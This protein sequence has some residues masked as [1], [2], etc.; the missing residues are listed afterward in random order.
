VGGIPHIQASETTAD[1]LVWVPVDKIAELTIYPSIND[2]ILDYVH[3]GKKGQYL[4]TLKQ[5]WL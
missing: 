3:T 1:D 5:I 4:G 2:A